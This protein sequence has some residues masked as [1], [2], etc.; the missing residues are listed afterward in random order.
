[1]IYLQ[2]GVRHQLAEG[3]QTLP[4]IFVEESDAGVERGP[5]PAL[6]TPEAGIV[7]VLACADHVLH[8]HAG[9]HQTLVRITQSNFGYTNFSWAHKLK[10]RGVTY[11][12]PHIY[13]CY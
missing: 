5:T 4:G 6:H 8:G 7:N 11:F 9:C 13:E 1:P 10:C 3:A 2:L 12:P